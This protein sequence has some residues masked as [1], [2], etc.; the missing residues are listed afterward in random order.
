M[1]HSLAT[2]S[3]LGYVRTET[4]RLFST[5]PEEANANDVIGFRL[6]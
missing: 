4:T 1:E 3:K 6:K 5:H 2:C